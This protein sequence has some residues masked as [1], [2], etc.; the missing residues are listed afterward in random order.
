MEYDLKKYKGKRKKIS[1]SFKG[2]A[3]YIN[4][5]WAG[6]ST[7]LFFVLVNSAITIIGPYLIGVATD[8]YIPSE[9]LDGLT[10][11]VIILFV[12]YL[13]GFA[14]NYLQI[15]L[16]GRVGQNVLFRVRNHIFQQ[17]QALPL[18]FFNANKSG[19]LIARINNDTEK[20]NQAFSETLLRF[21]GQIF[22]IIGIAIIMLTINPLL[23]G[24]AIGMGLILL[25]V[26]IFLTPWVRRKN[27]ESLDKNGDLSGQVQEGFRN[28]KVIVAFGRR[29]FLR[30]DFADVNNQAK[31]AA[32]KS[33]IA[34]GILAPFYDVGSYIVNIVILLVGIYLISTGSISFGILIAFILYV[35]RFYQPIRI[36]AQL[37]TSLQSSLAAWG[38]ISELLDLKSNLL[39]EA[40]ISQEKNT[41][42]VLAFNN[43]SFKYEDSDSYVIKNVSFDFEK[44]KTYALVGPTGGGKST[45]AKLIARLYDPTKGVVQLDGKNITSYS[46]EQL[47]KKIG[48]ILQEPFLFTGTLAENIVYGNSALFNEELL[49][50]KEEILHS[51]IIKVLTQYNLDSFLDFFD[52]GLKTNISN[53]SETISL[54][55]KQL[56]AFI[57]AILRSPEIL[58][59]DEAT[60]NIDTVTE[61]LLEKIIDSLPNETTKVIIAHRLNT[62]KKAD[63]IFFV[64]G[65]SVKDAGSFENAMELI[66][67]NR[68]VS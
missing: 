47:G 26:T 58:I 59:L 31:Q 28:F 49:Q 68:L 55:Q 29:D 57:R 44:G 11:S 36:L 52:E 30:K 7:A 13:I 54:G 5:S 32:T 60:A 25:L 21:V 14:A 6:M 48:F 46:E 18:R 4:G 62:I 42:S 65:D 38:R 2:I 8:E 66:T 22:V 17:I 10:Q 51:K 45:T 20:L 67:N 63:Q 27:R 56:V 19:D 40:D 43:V 50:N 39:V 9:D 37:F 1:E 33:S 23:G 16:M 15:Y 24:I 53:N 34:N 12:L 61:N 41:S 64:A 35:D 3:K